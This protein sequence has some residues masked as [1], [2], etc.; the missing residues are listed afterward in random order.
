MLTDAEADVSASV[1]MTIW[2][3]LACQTPNRRRSQS[4]MQELNWS[5]QRLFKP[6]SWTMRSVSGYMT[7]SSAGGEEV[8]HDKVI[9][10]TELVTMSR[11]AGLVIGVVAL[12]ITTG[13]G[14]SWPP[15]HVKP[16]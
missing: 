2:S 7:P 8:M 6:A 11:R 15:V 5:V 13:A 12:M 10:A 1:S 16:Q 4:S 9:A 3:T 14:S